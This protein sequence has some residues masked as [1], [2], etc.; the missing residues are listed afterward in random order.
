MLLSSVVSINSNYTSYSLSSFIMYTTFI[1]NLLNSVL[2]H[3]IR[4]KNR[5]KC[6]HAPMRDAIFLSYLCFIWKVSTLLL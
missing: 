4:A 6:E 1:Y 5:D 2:L 3:V